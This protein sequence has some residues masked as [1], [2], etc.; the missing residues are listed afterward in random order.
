MIPMAPLIPCEL[1]VDLWMAVL[2]FL[3]PPQWVAVAITC[4]RLHLLATSDQLWNAPLGRHFPFLMGP[5][6]S[7]RLLAYEV[8]GDQRR[9]LLPLMTGLGLHRKGQPVV[10]A[11]AELMCRNLHDG[12]V[13]LLMFGCKG[14]GRTTLLAN[15]M[16]KEDLP[17]PDDPPPPPSSEDED[18]IPLT[19]TGSLLQLYHQA[20]Y[21][22]ASLGAQLRYDPVPF[23]AIV[24]V[25]DS[26]D[27]RH[28]HAAREQLS[29]VIAMNE[30]QNAKLLI[31]ANK[32]DLPNALPAAAVTNTLGLP[33]QLAKRQ[34]AVYPACAL[35]GHGLPEAFEWLS[36]QLALDIHRHQRPRSGFFEALKRL[37]RRE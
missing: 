18:F 7:R 5:G 34:W 1:P 4:R 29:R 37:W 30:L 35:T 9:Q 12:P 33:L 24:W 28:L 13:K 6:G 23:A 16:S 21:D 27:P 3:R 10:S 14:A 11:E 22:S 2:L 26:S 8:Y 15:L 36:L 31:L 17:L 19:T 32:Q 25:V 20:V